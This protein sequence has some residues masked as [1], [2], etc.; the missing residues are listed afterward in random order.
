MRNIV[1]TGLPGSGKSSIGKLLEKE[2]AGKLKPVDTDELIVRRAGVPIT[3]IFEK[4]G[5]SEFRRLENETVKSLSDNDGM[6]IATGGGTVV[7]PENMRLLKKKGL[8]F[9]LKTSV[10]EILNRIASKTDRPLLNNTDKRTRLEELSAK[11]K[12]SYEAADFIIDTNGKTPENTAK[13]IAR[14]YYENAKV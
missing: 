8:V 4:H 1:L 3:D 5:E 2:F 9:Y 13:E 6:I 7:N 11:R 10:E 12:N 14:V